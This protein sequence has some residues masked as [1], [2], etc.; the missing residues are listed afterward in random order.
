MTTSE[1]DTSTATHS[2][3]AAFLRLALDAK[4]A[5]IDEVV[6]W[7]D[8][9]VLSEARP[10]AWSIDLALCRTW[11]LQRVSD[12]LAA[13]SV[14]ADGD[15]VRSLLAARLAGAVLRGELDAQRAIALAWSLPLRKDGQEPFDALTRAVFATT[16][17]LDGVEEGWMTPAAAAAIFREAFEPFAPREWRA[18]TDVA[19]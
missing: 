17:C 2:E 5:T 9:V 12:A 14:G 8:S 6:R 18:S 7:A 10:P 1:T 15:I 13:A 19:P 16:E 4:L 3:I 11:P